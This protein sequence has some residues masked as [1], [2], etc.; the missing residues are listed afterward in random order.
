MPSPPTGASAKKGQTIPALVGLWGLRRW[1]KSGVYHERGSGLPCHNG[2]SSTK[3]ASD[4]AANGQ[5]KARSRWA[6]DR[7]I[8]ERR[9]ADNKFEPLAQA[10][11]G[12][13]DVD[14]PVNAPTSDSGQVSGAHRRCRRRREGRWE[15]NL[16]H[17]GECD[18]RKVGTRQHSGAM[19]AGDA[20]RDGGGG[21]G[22]DADVRGCIDHAVVLQLAGRR[23]A[24]SPSI[25][26]SHRPV[27]A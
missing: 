27:E 1:R 7:S 24:T 2:P 17:R 5:G 9:S 10:G 3:H 25:A 8:Q 20:G 21:G 15:P 18:P 22:A 12:A 23:A 19:Q 11:G 4:D 26:A 13:P 6:T 16:R 14:K